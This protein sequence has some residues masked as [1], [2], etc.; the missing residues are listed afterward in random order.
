MHATEMQARQRLMIA[1]REMMELCMRI[2]TDL[3]RLPLYEAAP[4]CRFEGTMCPSSKGIARTPVLPFAAGR[5]SVITGIA[6]RVPYFLEAR[7]ANGGLSLFR[8]RRHA[9]LPSPSAWTRGS[10]R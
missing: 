4:Q 10:L 1:I 6:D 3:A 7:R 8:S 9:R 5:A 2:A